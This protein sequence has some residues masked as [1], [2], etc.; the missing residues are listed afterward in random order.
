MSQGAH[1]QSP[2]KVR[3]MQAHSTLTSQYWQK[4]KLSK[5]YESTV[6]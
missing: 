5:I 6:V 2:S 4:N 1:G 3:A